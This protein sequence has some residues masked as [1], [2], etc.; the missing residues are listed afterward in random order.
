MRWVVLTTHYLDEA[1]ALAGRVC[2]LRDGRVVSDGD[3]E[4]LRTRIG[5][6]QLRCRSMLDAQELASWAEVEHVEAQDGHLVLARAQVEQLLRRLLARDP[7]LAALEVRAPDLTDA[8]L[9]LTDMADADCT[10][11][12]VK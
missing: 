10:A 7:Q 8:F 4:T 9:A 3:V 12:E 6:K 2:V 1:Q 11:R 5:R